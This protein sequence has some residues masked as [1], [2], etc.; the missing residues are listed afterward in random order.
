[1]KYAHNTS[2]LFLK[3]GEMQWY[4]RSEP[5]LDINK[6]H[7]FQKVNSVQSKHVQEHLSSINRLEGSAHFLCIL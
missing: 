3:K 1:M 6:I 5:Y 2:K 7:V 4:K